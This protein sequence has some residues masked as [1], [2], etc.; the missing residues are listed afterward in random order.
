MPAKPW[1]TVHGDL[2]GPFPSGESI[3]VIIDACS[4]W[5]EVEIIRNTSSKTIINKLR[6]VFSRQGFPE[7]FVSDNGSN[8]TSSEFNE[9]LSSCGITHRT[10]TPYWPQANGIVER[11]NR[12]LLKA[13]K[14]AVIENKDWRSSIPGS[15]NS[16]SEQCIMGLVFFTTINNNNGYWRTSKNLI[17]VFLKSSLTQHKTDS[18]FQ[19]L[20]SNSNSEDSC[21]SLN[22]NDKKKRS[23][24]GGITCCV[25]HCFNNSKTNKELSFYVIP[26]EKNVRKLW[27]SKISRKNFTPSTSHRVC[28]EH[29]VGGKKTYMN[30]VPTV[31]PKTIKITERKA[32]E[33]RNSLGLIP[34]IALPTTGR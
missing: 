31:V 22:Y 33:T 10:M 21:T 19:N 24:G 17:L 11:F 8:L 32:R 30:N 1:E 4:R 34:E 20:S 2:L 18:F 16:V 23:V 3:L 14:V 13:I 15:H 7:I 28:S 29:F 12:T 27:L 9:Y 25:P 6:K 5:P 26:K